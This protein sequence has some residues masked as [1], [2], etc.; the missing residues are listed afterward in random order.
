VN[1]KKALLLLFSMPLLLGTS[2]SNRGIP[3]TLRYAHSDELAWVSE[4]EAFDNAGNLRSELF[5]PS[6]E[7]LR[8]NLAANN[9]G[10]CHAFMVQP[11]SERPLTDASLA[12][13]SASARS[14][15]VG[16]VVNSGRGF[17]H[18]L[19]GTLIGVEVKKTLSASDRHRDLV[20]F[21]IPSAT[22]ITPAGVLCSRSFTKVAVPE[23]A[24]TLIAFSYEPPND[25]G[26]LILPI[27]PDRDLIVQRKAV[28][29]H[30]PKQFESE[31]AGL[32]LDEIAQRVERHATTDPRKR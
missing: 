8:I 7:P 17:Y 23:S 18:A 6:A 10:K 24:D 14:I 4:S 15:I 13:A 5:G 31:L 2:M 21:F 12:E 29:V 20:Y 28:R 16:Q 25:Q 1:R 30:T 27:D 9:D 11:P 19:P 22:F 32:H 3:T 26:G